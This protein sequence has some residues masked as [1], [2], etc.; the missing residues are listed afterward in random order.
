MRTPQLK[1][2]DLIKVEGGRGDPM[3]VR[4][5]FYDCGSEWIT[6]QKVATGEYFHIPSTS[7]I[8]LESDA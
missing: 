3:I 4:F 7:A 1:A 5:T 2:G 6:V 8:L